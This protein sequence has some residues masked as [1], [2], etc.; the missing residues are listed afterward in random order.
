MSH[1]QR[2]VSTRPNAYPQGEETDVPEEH[3]LLLVQ[4][5]WHCDENAHSYTPYKPE[6][7][8]GSV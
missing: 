2:K 3:W 4:V 8:V 6:Q 1:P 7:R 5:P